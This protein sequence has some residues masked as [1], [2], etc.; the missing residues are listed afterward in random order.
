[1]PRSRTAKQFME[2]KDADIESLPLAMQIEVLQARV[3][4]CEE[5]LKQSRDE[6]EETEGIQNC[7]LYS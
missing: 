6:L 3:S 4:K 1:M 2:S 5:A 7:L